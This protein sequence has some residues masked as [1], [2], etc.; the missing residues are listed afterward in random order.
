MPKNRKRIGGKAGKQKIF[1]A[2]CRHC[3]LVKQPVGRLNAYVLRVRC[4]HAMWRKKSG[5][6]K[7]YKYF[8]LVRRTM[9]SCV[10]YEPMGDEKTF[11]KELKVSLPV[12]DEIYTF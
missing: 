4:G 5:E 1:C 12:K 8:T 3:L 9:S 6:E 10:H 7:V 2:N 11:I